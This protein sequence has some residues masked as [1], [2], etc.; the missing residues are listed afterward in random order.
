MTPESVPDLRITAADITPIWRAIAG[1]GSGG[2][3]AAVTDQPQQQTQ[4]VLPTRLAA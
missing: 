2:R 3:L 1:L 4:S